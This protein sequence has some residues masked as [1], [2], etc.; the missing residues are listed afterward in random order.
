MSTVHIYQ[1]EVDY[2]WY[3]FVPDTNQQ[4]G[5]FQSYKE[6]EENYILNRKACPNCG[7]D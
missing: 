4:D 5:P 2:L 6:A 7:D 3:W 1:N